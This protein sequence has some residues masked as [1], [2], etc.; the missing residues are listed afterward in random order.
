MKKYL[1]IIIQGYDEVEIEVM[2]KNGDKAQDEA[3]KQVNFNGYVHIV[4]EI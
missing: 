2:A 3:M 4:E 1:V